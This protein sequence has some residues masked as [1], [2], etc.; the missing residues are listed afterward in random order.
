MPSFSRDKL[1]E[2]L[3]RWRAAGLIDEDTAVTIQRWEDS[4]K[5]AATAD[6]AVA[7]APTVRIAV[8]LG[9]VLLAAGL[10]PFVSAHWDG[11]P[12]QGRLALLMVAVVALHGLAGLLT[13][14]F[15]AMA[16]GLHGAGTVAL[17]GGI[18]LSGQ[19]FHLQ[20]H[21]PAGL[22]LW[23]IGA[24]LGW[25]LLHQWPQLA[26]LALLVPAWLTSTWFQRCAALDLEADPCVLVPAAGLLLLSLT[27]LTASSGRDAPSPVRRVLSGVGGVALLPTALAWGAVATAMDADPGGLPVG[28]AWLGWTVAILG[29]LLLG[30][31]LRHRRAWPLGVAAAWMLVDLTIRDG[32]LNPLSFAWWALGA[33][34]LMVWGSLEGRSERINLAATLM[35]MTLIGFYFSEVMGRLD[36]SLSLVG[37]GLLVLGGS[38][39][40][41]RLRRRM[42]ARTLPPGGR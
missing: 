3:Q 14:R 24:G 7:L 35:A 13:E 40:L 5:V 22:L 27:Y 19:I 26:L 16:V 41:E 36:R 1:A 32:G 29:P 15:R 6:G 12:P 10:L 42:V 8:A 28:M 17:G 38:W 30:W 9:S 33:M 39:A 23:A 31:W 21:W 34:A 18:F 11:M 2:Q 37:L 4:R 25:L 20:A